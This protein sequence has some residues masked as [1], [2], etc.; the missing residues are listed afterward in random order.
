MTFRLS[1]RLTILCVAASIVLIGE[2]NAKTYRAKSGSFRTPTRP[3][4]RQIYILIG[5]DTVKEKISVE[6]DLTKLGKYETV[7]IADRT[8][9]RSRDKPQRYMYKKRNGQIKVLD[10]SAPRQGWQ[11]VATNRVHF[12]TELEQVKIEFESS[13]RRAYRGFSGSYYRFDLAAA[14]MEGRCP[15]DDLPW[16]NSDRRSCTNEFAGTATKCTGDFACPKHFIPMGVGECQQNTW[17]LVCAPSITAW[18]IYSKECTP[19]N[20]ESCPIDTTYIEGVKAY[21]SIYFGD[22]NATISDREPVSIKKIERACVPIC[23]PRVPD[24]MGHFPSDVTNQAELKKFI[25]CQRCLYIYDCDFISQ[26]AA[27]VFGR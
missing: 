23:K 4:R 19:P 10:M 14:E 25:R 22:L 18:G 5:S 8:T 21:L 6:L 12:D 11:S 24:C 13:N 16:S 17:R 3:S 20:E 27:T 26:R 7:K 2:V 9:G 1:C 15:I